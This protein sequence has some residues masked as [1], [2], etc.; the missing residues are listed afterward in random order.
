MH[1]L[2]VILG[3]NANE[4]RSTEK[5]TNKPID[6]IFDIGNLSFYELLNT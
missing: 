5:G 1:D 6:L 2:M 4:L 3:S